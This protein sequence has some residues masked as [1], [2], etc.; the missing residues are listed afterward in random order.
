MAGGTTRSAGTFEC[1]GLSVVNGAQTIGSLSSCPETFADACAL[2]RVPIRIISLNGAPEGFSSLITK[3][4]NTQN[5]IDARNFVALDPHQERL[6]AEFLIDKIDYEYRQG[7]IEL[8]GARKLDLTEATIALACSQQEVDLA[9]QAKREIGKLWEDI[10]RPPY[11][12]LFNSSTTSEDIWER[13]VAFRRIN[14]QLEP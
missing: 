11:R 5:R 13:V 2:A 9:V 4:N 10:S 8:S 1:T 6:R 14:E 3:T 7:E 12:T